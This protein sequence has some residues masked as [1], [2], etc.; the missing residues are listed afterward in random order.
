MIRISG[1]KHKRKYINTPHNFKTRPTSS[2]LRESIFN[3]LLHSKHLP[4]YFKNM[5]IIDI[6]A[7]S[8]ALGIEAL[9]RGCKYCTFVDSSQD[10]VETIKKNIKILNEE[11]NTNIIKANAIKPIKF[12]KQ[13]DLCF[14]DPPYDIP[15]FSDILDKWI[16]SNLVKNNTL[17]VYEKHKNTPLKLKKNIDIIEKKQQGISEIII[18]KKISCSSK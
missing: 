18:L 16:K 1:G 13:Y 5:E 8:G 3:I 2:R 15:D 11:K 7:G 10:A 14:F 12:I 4:V 17:Y 9:S 6:F